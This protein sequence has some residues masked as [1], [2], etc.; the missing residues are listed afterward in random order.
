MLHS[1]YCHALLGALVTEL[2]RIR[3]LSEHSNR[4]FVFL[5]FFFLSSFTELEDTTYLLR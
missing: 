1:R 2:V 3:I 4:F 5:S